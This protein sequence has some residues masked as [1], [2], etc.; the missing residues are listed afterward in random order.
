[1][2]TPDKPLFPDDPTGKNLESGQDWTH[3]KTRVI[4]RPLAPEPRPESAH[5]AVDFSPAPKAAP[6]QPRGRAPTSQ[7]AALTVSGITLLAFIM[8]A[9]ASIGRSDA[10]V[11][12]A[13]TQ[14]PAEASRNA[15][16]LSASDIGRTPAT[17]SRPNT[18]PELPRQELHEETAAI[19]AAD[20]P[21]PP[22]SAAST[23]SARREPSPARSAGHA[24]EAVVRAFYGALGRGD[25]EEAS[26]QVVAEKRSSEVFSPQAISR[27]YGG[28]RK[29][30][31]LTAITP[32]ANGA[33]RVRYRYSAGRRPC[34]GGAVVSLTSR[35]GHD[36]IRSIR[37]LNGC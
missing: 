27:F 11:P 26:A 30:L 1:M 15:T 24:G 6:A 29:P 10:S 35:D 23:G 2:V 5:G 32:L 20:A 3:Q 36:L 28:L 7:V 31:R 8:A 18:A 19:I 4:I 13:P 14:P 25:G 17:T 9:L 34:N 37:T 12:L 21:A 22:P 33:Y 16:E